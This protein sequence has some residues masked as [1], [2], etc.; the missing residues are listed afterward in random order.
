MP[1]K[2]KMW[3]IGSKHPE[4]RELE[5]LFRNAKQQI[6]N[7]GRTHPEVASQLITAVNQYESKHSREQSRNLVGWLYDREN[8]I[9]SRAVRDSRAGLR[10]MS[11]M[12]SD[13]SDHW[14]NELNEVARHIGLDT[15]P[16]MRESPHPNR[17][18][19]LLNA[20]LLSDNAAELDWQFRQ[21]EK[22]I[23]QDQDFRP[24]VR[25]LYRMAQEFDEK[26]P[27]QDIP[28]SWFGMSGAIHQRARPWLKTLSLLVKEAREC[29]RIADS[30][31]IYATFKRMR[32]A[33]EHEEEELRDAVIS[34]LN[35][36]GFHY[37]HRLL[38]QL[39][40]CYRDNAYAQGLFGQMIDLAE[41]THLTLIRDDLNTWLRRAKNIGL[42]HSDKVI[43]QLEEL[44]DVFAAVN[45]NTSLLRPDPSFIVTWPKK[46]PGLSQVSTLASEI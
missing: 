20:P 11:G 2:T 34:A 12:E 31:D 44:S 17:S 7:S 22:S 13:Q 25:Q 27:D 36:E 30:T 37:T 45:K 10:P 43:E 29:S 24:T 9:E 23:R 21:W 26:F 19:R 28:A 14:G 16:M 3:N 39:H 40:R 5:Q 42:L 6:W 15:K 4:D 41:R 35:Q 46:W 18:H 32:R 33:D 1:T 38:T 8:F